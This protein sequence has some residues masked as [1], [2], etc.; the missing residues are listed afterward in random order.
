M[1]GNVAEAPKSRR[2]LSP[3]DRVSEVLFGLI[4]ALTFTCTISVAEAGREEVRE[5]LV[6]ALS[7]NIAWGLVDG[8]MFVVLGLIERARAHASGE[9]A[10]R[11]R[12]KGADFLGAIAVLLVVS[13]TTIPVALPFVFVNQAHRALRIS[14]AIALVMLFVAG[15]TL[16][17]Y[18]KLRPVLM[19]LAMLAIG[20]V[21][22]GATIALGG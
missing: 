4:M 6:G 12:L 10:E 20:V 15:W 2:V 21:L 3:V 8:V 16:G 11:P 14:N 9:T 5:V 19:G 17:S 7:C 1:M 22:V 18:S 13:L